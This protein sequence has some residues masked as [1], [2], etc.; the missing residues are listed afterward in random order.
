MRAVNLIPG[1]QRQG[2][3]SLTGRSGGGALIVLGMVA[4]LAVLVLMYGS[5][6]HQISSQNG[7]VAALT[8]Q[9]NAI[10]ARTGRLAPYTSF[11]SMANQRTQTVAQ[12]VQARFD[13]SHALHELGRVL[14][15]D[16]ALATLHGTVG[17]AGEASSS[18]A[19]AAPAAGPTAASSTPP[20]STPVF[21]LTGCAVSQSVVA[22]TLQR[23]KLMDGA[24]EVQLQSSTQS[25]S[26]GSSSSSSSSAG[27]GGG[28]CSH[29]SFAAQ[30]LF[31]GL[32]SA[33]APSVSAG[34]S[35]STAAAHHAGAEEQ[36][37]AQGRAVPR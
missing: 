16:T 14:P 18:S 21:T 31:Q 32:P 35:A 24:S 13:W 37:S 17:A 28:G 4:G 5:A 25:A 19:A 20:G 26:S 23:L 7:Q 2:A 27:G 9:A 8:A 3:G 6:N 11:V 29:A 34:T 33:P 15:T 30:V 10:Q 1:E 36:V 12:L 22:Q